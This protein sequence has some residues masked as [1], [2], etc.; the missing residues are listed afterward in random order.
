VD[1]HWVARDTLALALVA[2]V[3]AGAASSAADEPLLER[4][5]VSQNQFLQTETL[6]YYVSSKVGDRYDP[7]RLKQDFRRLWDT[8]FLDDLLLDVR[9]GS[10]GK[11]ATFVVRERRRVQIV[12]Y[13]GT[14]SITTANIN[15]KLKEKDAAIK[16]DT[17]YDVAKA[18]RVEGII[19]EMLVDGGHPLATVRHETKALG[20]AGTQVS[21]IADEGPKARVKTVTFAG[22]TVFADGALRHQMKKIKQWGF[23]NL[24]WLG[25]KTAFTDDKW[26][27]DRT[28]LRDF[29]L[30]NGYATA[31]VGE[32]TVTY[33]DGTSGLFRK[34]AVKWVTVDIPVTEG[35]QYRI[36]SMTFEGLKVLK[37]PYARQFFTLGPGDVYR[38]RRFKKSFDKLRDT[39][40]ALG[41]F[42]FTGVTKRSPNP[43][44]KTVDVVISMEEDKQYFVGQIHFTGNETTRDKVIR[45]EVYLNEGDVFNTE[46]L[47][48]SVRRIN[49]LGYFKEMKEA[50]GLAPSRRG[51]DKI[52]VTFKLEEQNRNQFQFGG[53]VSGT[54]GTFLSASFSTANF[55]GLGET[56]A[57]SAQTGQRSRNYQVTVSE[58]YFLDRP[59]TAGTDVFLRRTTYLS[60]QN[61]VGFSEQDQGISLTSGFPVSRSSRFFGTYGYQIVDIYGVDEKQLVAL[62]LSTASYLQV[63]RRYESRVTPSWVRDS[64]NSPF[65]PRSGSK[66]TV[67]FQ[68]VGGPLGGSVSYYSPTVETIF[69]HPVTRRMAVGLRGQAAFVSPFS[70]TTEVPY[71]QRFFLGGENQIRG[72]DL[73]SVSPLDRQTN[74]ATG[75]NKYVL[76][77]AEYY[78]D[79]FGPLRLL[80]FFDAGEAYLKGQGIDLRTLST[81]TGAEARFVMPVLNVPFRLIY[82]WNPNRASFQPATAFKFAVGTT[83]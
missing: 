60:S 36:G 83:F 62:G 7:L 29:Y 75:G 28:N 41:Y 15:D 48:F 9:D 16:V 59:I 2:T 47:K 43:E 45:R 61:F 65:T 70:T 71:Y 74:A 12:D 5:E 34:K 25:G 23:W 4:I 80:L 10:K 18:R 40:G 68:L 55:L 31:D 30:D 14:K 77:N 11:I 8:G 79:V 13:R 46:A 76:F 72:Y 78:F 17:F 51:D 1:R 63:G 26:V 58:P 6:L 19:R 44:T 24:S 53:G 49:Q 56:L 39:Y 37:E 32:P 27:E 20:P 73:R 3:G 50:P 66:Q 52:D 42:Q 54:E 22:N 81:S 69:Y 35:D 33:S 67:S 21:F 38:E 57:L 64:V 82:S